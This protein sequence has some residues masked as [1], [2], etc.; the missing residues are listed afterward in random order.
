MGKIFKKEKYDT[1]S[2]YY[3]LFG[4]Q[5]AKKINNCFYL[6]KKQKDGEYSS[7]HWYVGWHDWE[8]DISYEECGYET[9]NAELNISLLGWH[10]VFKLPWKSKRFPHGDCDAPKWGIS[11]F[12]NTFWIHRGGNGN[13]NGG[14]K[15]W[16][17]DLPFF[18]KV[19]VKHT[20]E[21]MSGMVDSESLGSKD[22]Y[23]YYSND[24]RVKKY[25][26]TYTDS[27]D[28]EVVG[29]TY[30]KEYREWRPKWLT[31]ISWFATKRNYIEIEFDKEVGKEKGSWKGGCVGCSY[32]LLPGETPEECIRRMEKERKF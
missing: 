11:I 7:D 15:W 1:G 13:M 24:E 8:F 23:V 29:C 2:K 25:H 9:G 18:S 17:W 28:G 26:Y 12:D 6:L 4:R 27:Y 5:V 20:V 30:W 19:H 31:W 32:D 21:T 16:T 14:C 10:S 3:Y 22:P